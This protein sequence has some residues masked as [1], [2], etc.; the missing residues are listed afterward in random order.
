MVYSRTVLVKIL[1]KPSRSRMWAIFLAFVIGCVASDT[2][3]R[4]PDATTLLNFINTNATI[5]VDFQD[6]GVAFE[7]TS[8]IRCL[9]YKLKSLNGQYYT[10]NQTYTSGTRPNTKVVE[11]KLDEKEPIMT[12]S[13]GSGEP[14]V[15]YTL[16]EANFYAKCAAF[17]VQQLST[18]KKTCRLHAWGGIP[19][20][21]Q[22]SCFFLFTRN[23]KTKVQKI[24]EPHCPRFGSI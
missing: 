2:N 5:W 18:A 24:Y 7:T 16:L 6:D 1:N 19:S 23:C 4:K 20:S 15:K 17:K 13:S 22:T 3:K 14:D 9:N 21:N 10:F 8:A 12:V 11:A